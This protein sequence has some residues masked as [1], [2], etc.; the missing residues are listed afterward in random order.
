MRITPSTLTRGSAVAAVVAGAIYIVIQFI[1]P[2]DV[3]T[4]LS[5]GQWATVHILSFSEAVLALIGVTGIYLRQVR[6]FGLLGLIGYLMFG[7]FFVLQAAFNFTEAFIAPLLVTTAPQ[8]ADDFVG[9]FGRHTAVTD[10]GP[11]AALP[12]VAGLLYVLGALIFGIGV[13]R[14]RVLSRGA[15]ILLIA[16]AA[17]TPIAGALLPHTL[18]RG[19][20]IPM[21]LALIWLGYS[22]WSGQQKNSIPVQ[23]G[24][25]EVSLSRVA[26]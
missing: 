22:L 18:E 24:A 14:A 16:A 4:S 11:L 2:A 17:V 6:Q 15:G 20:A 1:H 9:L 3:V 12:S 10:L 26:K 23:V 7:F 19:A 25:G 21:G 13:I 5:T 8:F